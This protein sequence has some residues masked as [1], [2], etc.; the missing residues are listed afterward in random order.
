[1]TPDPP[2]GRP[3]DN[4]ELGRQL[5]VDGMTRVAI[6]SEEWFPE[7]QKVVLRICQLYPGRTLTGEKLGAAVE[8][9]YRPPP[10]P[11]AWGALTKWALNHKLITLHPDPAKRRRRME[12]PRSHGRTTDVYVIR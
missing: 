10:K 7:A 4:A 3:G 11:Q 1:M 2:F 6:S 12:R 8:I 9:L 5:G